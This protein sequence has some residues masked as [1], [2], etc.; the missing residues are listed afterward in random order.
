MFGETY[1]L[2]ASGG[3]KGRVFLTTLP[4]GLHV[5]EPDLRLLIGLKLAE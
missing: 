3:V 2:L 4:P 5:A 1:A